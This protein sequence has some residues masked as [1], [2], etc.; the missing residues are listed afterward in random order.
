M[1]NQLCRYAAGVAAAGLL[2]LPAGC[3]REAQAP[4]AP[5]TVPVI[6][7]EVIQRDQILYSEF[8]GQI[9]GSNDVEVRA[10]VE[11]FLAGVHFTEGSPVR[12]NA[13]LYTID[14]RPFQSALAQA[15]GMALQAQAQWEKARRDTNRLGPLWLKNA[16][17]RQQLDDALAAE[18][19]A[20]A[21][22][23]G[24][25]AAKESAAIQLGFTRIEA[26]LEGLVGKNNVGVGNLVGR[27]ESTLLTTVSQIDPFLVRFSV[28]EQLYLEWKQRGAERPGAGKGRVELFLADGTAYPHRGDF[29]FADREVDPK[30]GTLLIQATFPNPD[31]LIRPGQFGRVR[32]PIAM[33]TNA[34]LVPQRAVMELQATYSVFVV[35]ADNKAEFRKIDPGERVGSYFIARSGLKAG[36]KVV[37]EGMQKLQNN[38]PLAPVFTNLPPETAAASLLR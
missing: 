38:C 12:S 33:V 11:G 28:N 26:P 29:L 24:A 5:P 35:G 27:G 34:V 6:A 13:L 36:E 32:V 14:D 7:T 19:S 3:R 37:I 16:V 9:L 25:E 2:W 30:T 17:S 20:A 15:R 1:P 4:P 23:A 22:L 31:R 8:L 18:R 21:A 10:R